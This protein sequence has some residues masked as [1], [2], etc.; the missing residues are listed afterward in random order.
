MSDSRELPF[1]L[2]GPGANPY[3][4]IDLELEERE[5]FRARNPRPRPAPTEQLTLTSAVAPAESVVARTRAPEGSGNPYASLVEQR[6][7]AEGESSGIS[8]ADF[9]ARC[10][11]VFR[12]YV[13]IWRR[14][15]PLPPHYRDFI[16]R[17]RTRSAPYRKRLVTTLERYS[18]ADV[19][20]LTAQFNREQDALTAAKL[21]ELEKIAETAKD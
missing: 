18:L 1:C 3:S 8:M 20:Q 6:D 13:P 7:D 5:A 2:T 21:V 12:P 11:V 19:P 17:N 4:R 9:E 10:R 16:A 15:G 14:T